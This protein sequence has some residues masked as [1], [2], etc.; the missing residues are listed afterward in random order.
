LLYYFNRFGFE[1]KVN[2]EIQFDDT[3]K[4]TCEL[5]FA[6]AQT[7]DFEYLKIKGLPLSDYQIIKRRRSVKVDL[8][9]DKNVDGDYI[10][11]LVPENIL[12]LSTPLI[13]ASK[14]E[15]TTDYSEN[16]DSTGDY[17][18]TWY[19]VNPCQSLIEQG[20]ENSSSFFNTTEKKKRGGNP[21]TVSEFY[22]IEAKDNLKNININIKNLD[23][24]L[25]TD[26]DNRGNGY[27]SMSLLVK[28]GV[29]LAT[30]TEIVLLNAYEEEHRTFTKVGDFNAKIADVKRDEKIWVFFQFKVRQSADVAEANPR[31]ECFTDIMLFHQFDIFFHQ[32]LAYSPS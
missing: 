9:S 11:P 1:A 30:A 8:F 2:L 7:D 32:F 19:Y 31:F 23:L 21:A 17:S 28:Y 25:T 24:K 26:V 20:V 22:L 5:D 29:D 16:L 4:Y 13:Q 3:T 18:T 14:W 10:A 27:V 15:Q 12:M 6:T